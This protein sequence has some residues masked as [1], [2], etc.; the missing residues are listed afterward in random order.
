[1]IV[2]YLQE[3]TRQIDLLEADFK[4]LAKNHASLS[5][6]YNTVQSAHEDL[7]RN[8]D[9]LMQQMNVQK[10]LN[11]EQTVEI[12]KQKEDIC[13]LERHLEDAKKIESDLREKIIQLSSLEPQ[14]EL[15][16]QHLA[17]GG[18]WCETAAQTLSARAEELQA[19]L[20][21]AT[22]AR[23]EISS[24]SDQLNAAQVRAVA[25]ETSLEMS[26]SARLEADAARESAERS[27]SLMKEEVLSLRS[28]HK[29]MVEVVQAMREAE[30]EASTN[31]D[32]ASLQIEKLT[33][34]L[35][36][37]QQQV[38]DF[39]AREQ[40]LNTSLEDLTCKYD[41][42]ME[43]NASLAESEKKSCA[44]LQEV[45]QSLSLA[46]QE[47]NHL[48]DTN[49]LAKTCLEES[50]DSIRAK[51]DLIWNLQ[52]QI[53]DY[54][55]ACDS[56]KRAADAIREHCHT[57][58]A[59]LELLKDALLS[60]KSTSDMVQ[61]LVAFAEEEKSE[62]TKEN[63]ELRQCSDKLRQELSIA[64]ENAHRLSKAAQEILCLN[65]EVDELKDELKSTKE[66]VK[67]I[68]LLKEDSEK[69]T[70]Q[71][72]EEN[73]ALTERLAVLE[74]DMAVIEIVKDQFEREAMAE[75]D[76]AT[77]IRLYCKEAEREVS[78][79]KVDYE[80]LSKSLEA[81]YDSLKPIV[82]E[83]EESIR[84]HI[85]ASAI[86][87]QDSLI[88]IS[89]DVGKSESL[90]KSLRDI[91][92]H[93]SE[94]LASFDALKSSQT[95][96]EMA[97]KSWT[98]QK[99]AF[100]IVAKLALAIAVDSVSG[101]DDALHSYNKIQSDNEIS[102]SMETAGLTG[103]WTSLAKLAKARSGV[104]SAEKLRD[105]KASL[106][107]TRIALAQSKLNCEKQ[108]QIR[109]SVERCIQNTGNMLDSM[110]KSIECASGEVVTLSDRAD[111]DTIEQFN[112]RVDTLRSSLNLLL[113]RYR[114]MARSVRSVK[115][116]WGSQE[117]RPKKSLDEN[118][119]QMQE[120]QFHQNDKIPAVMPI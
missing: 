113:R 29:E 58:E 10:H 11:R 38:A 52:E 48:R 99:K 36:S 26:N 64:K 68:A 100:R 42:C 34:S 65:Q 78:Q 114:S 53:A 97:E 83:I 2:F 6:S 43:E 30:E 77:R 32:N 67:S 107:E 110:I 1:M 60:D 20:F 120:N 112:T 49:N 87:E 66:E 31:F 12:S 40:S 24:L 91:N 54:K 104:K 46:T 101:S 13:R 93:V 47:I 86:C 108:V 72:L 73:K 55:S 116:S 96:H 88:D 35:N 22:A 59:N 7:E 41:K 23:R 76:E 3:A 18:S 50:Y 102:N 109:E 106:N 33:E 118:Q 111:G 103:I 117:M 4:S 119:M 37:V 19:A 63:D 8:H 82:G 56:E 70:L 84:K 51:E 90:V 44:M 74:K 61:R 69:K 115:K 79:L 85:G 27:L 89:H 16:K 75:K 92:H 45:Q 15:L 14:I 57:L 9:A 94:I 39:V 21:E 28:Q 25:A 17:E 98:G 105:L 81:K 71:M 80:I 95:K 5:K 62:L